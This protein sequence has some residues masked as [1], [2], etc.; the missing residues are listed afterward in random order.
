MRSIAAFEIILMIVASFNVI[1]IVPKVEAQPTLASLTQ[2]L[3]PPSVKVCCERTTSGDFCQY[4]TDDQC[5]SKFRKASTSCEQTSFCKLGCGYDSIDGRCFKNTPRAG[6][7]QK[8]N[9]TWLDDKSCNVPQCEKGCC[10]LGNE[11]SFTTQAACKRETTLHQFVNMTF[12][13]DIKSELECVN[14]CRSEER[15]ACVFPDSTCKFTTRTECNSLVGEVQGNQTEKLI[16]VNPN[17]GFHPNMLCSNDNLG[18][19]CARQQKTACLPGKE[20][21][22]W[23]DSCG[24]PENIYD[25]DKRRSFN[26][27]FVLS[28]SGSCALN[29]ANDPSCGNCDF[30]EGTLCGEADK[31][32]KPTFG[33]FV[34]KDLS[35]KVINESENQEAKGSKK[36]GESWCAYD[37]KVGFG[38]DTVGSRHFRRL[39]IDGQELTEP[40][41]DFRE[42]I[43]M[44]GVQGEP[45]LGLQE[46]VS[47]KGDFVEAACRQ[48]RIKDCSVINDQ[49][50]CE[51][52]QFRDCIWVPASVTNPAG[53]CIP[54]VP[55]GLKFWEGE[56]EFAPE[57]DAS[58]VCGK[59]STRC[60]VSWVRGGGKRFFGV[61]KDWQCVTNCQCLQDEWVTAVASVCRSLGDCGLK[62]NFIG[63]KGRG[64]FSEDAPGKD[65]GGFAISFG[66]NAKDEYSFSNM[67]K[68]LALPAITIGGSGLYAMYLGGSFGAAVSPFSGTWLATFPSTVSAAGAQAAIWPATPELAA[69][70]GKE[71]AAE[72]ATTA[73]EKG[74]GELAVQGGKSVSVGAAGGASIFQTLN[75]VMWIYTIYQLID[76]LGKESK[77]EEYT[78]KCETWQPPFGGD[79]CERCG[80]DGKPCSEYRCESLGALCEL[81]NKGTKEELCVNKHPNDV[82]SPVITANRAVLKGNLTITEE[83]NKGYKINQKIPPFTPVALGITVNEPAQCKF[84]LNTSVKFQEMVNFFGESLFR[85]NHTM[86]FQLPSELAEDQ[87]LILTNGG[88]YN[89]YVRCADASGNAN[90]KDYYIQFSIE[91]GPDLTAPVIELTSINNR[92]FIPSNV[93]ETSLSVYVNEPSECKWSK[94]DKEYDLMENNFACSTSG[95]DVS[96]IYHGM[97]ECTT[98]L[99]GLE[100]KKDNAF[101]FRCKDQPAKSEEKRNINTESYKFTLR[102]TQPLKITSIGP[103][104]VLHDL[105]P[106]LIVSTSGGAENGR[107]VCGYSDSDVPITS[108]IEFLKTNSTSH[109]QPFVNMTSGE[110]PFFVKCQDVAGNLDQATTTFK[111][112]VDIIPPR[113]TQIYRDGSIL[114]L[115]TDEETTCEYSTTGTFGFGQGNPM[116]G[117]S[118][119]I[120]EAKL[121]SRFYYIVCRDKFNNELNARVYAR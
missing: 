103:S 76:W 27:G 42:E 102:G 118:N 31:K 2:T 48:N 36:L 16:G 59:A 99:T 13:E 72:A 35:C 3:N 66:T 80:E 70:L 33:D 8:G 77:T 106:V 32:T 40:C 116:T 60:K 69:A 6:C 81:V 47:V 109:E 1:L 45:P 29:G 10:V 14:F 18:T 9:C 97:Y 107:A 53:S 105:S 26:N 37:G 78:A 95:F 112:E 67:F 58:E 34:C 91:P 7:E 56:A 44:Q 25:A 61:G 110:Y 93:T 111:V 38:L 24:N 83:I 63:A 23:I 49:R 87:A 101:F 30:I 50:E 119:K 108:M 117:T 21:V 104:G 82:T 115:E 55:P 17:G 57:L 54:F 68:K 4:T 98:K 64:G 94:E 12:K 73:L 5:D 41:K 96:S 79:D 90:N 89:V 74:G 51:N 28:K 52:I 65:T 11:C 92:G 100:D 19:E 84:A 121:D 88:T 120:H 39:C 85:Y 20:E 114:H 22:Y 43:C 46:S 15:G 71:G 113:I 62:T 86:T 75:T